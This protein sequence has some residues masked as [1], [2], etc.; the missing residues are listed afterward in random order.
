MNF[1][2][3]ENEYF[4][5]EHCHSCA[6][7]GYLIVSPTVTVES[8]SELPNSFQEQLGFSLATATQVIQEIINPLKV[9]CAQFGEEGVELHFHIF[10]RTSK[11]T[12]EFL[13]AFPEQRDLIHGP[14][15]LD[16]AREK[17]NYSKEK[18]WSIVS[19]VTIEMRKRIT[20]VSK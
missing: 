18:V 19:P 13:K 3:D 9:Y 17:Y 10:P 14:V 4:T 11:I 20:R 6:V 15:L 8:I 7:P 5:I 1:T 2:I 12:S 16:W